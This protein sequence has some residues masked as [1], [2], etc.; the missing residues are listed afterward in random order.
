MAAVKR[1]SGTRIY[2]MILLGIGDLGAIILEVLAA[3][4]WEGFVTLTNHIRLFI[5]TYP[6]MG[7]LFLITGDIDLTTCISIACGAYLYTAFLYYFGLR[8]RLPWACLVATLLTFEGPYPRLLRRAAVTAFML[9]RDDSLRGLY[10]KRVRNAEVPWQD[11]SGFGFLFNFEGR[12]L[13]RE[14]CLYLV[15]TLCSSFDRPRVPDDFKLRTSVRVVDVLVLPLLGLVDWV[16]RY[17]RARKR[18]S[19]PRLEDQSIKML[20]GK[21]H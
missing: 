4:V 5:A 7:L 3:I 15:N 13:L 11:G 10:L 2:V 6:L 12:E 16:W 18:A 14:L 9:A 20:L 19:Q 1:P 8:D 21:Q 17:R